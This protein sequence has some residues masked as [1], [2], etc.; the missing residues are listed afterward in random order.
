MHVAKWERRWV[1]TTVVPVSKISCN[2]G[3]SSEQ[4]S[5]QQ[6]RRGKHPGCLPEEVLPQ[7]GFYPQFASRTGAIGMFSSVSVSWRRSHSA[8]AREEGSK[9]EL[10]EGD[11]YSMTRCFSQFD[12][13]E[14]SKLSGDTNPIHSQVS[15]AKAAG[16]E[17]CVVHGMLYAGL[18]PAIIGSNFVSSLLSSLILYAAPWKLRQLSS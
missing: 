5:Q 7:Q 6:L 10:T 12:V 8:E 16:L 13:D 18:F 4:S 3:N 17:G 14:Y 2:E 15:A 11:I 1:W 9:V